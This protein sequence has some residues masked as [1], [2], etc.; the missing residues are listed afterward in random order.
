M[1]P[2]LLVL[3]ILGGIC[4]WGLL[5]WT[6]LRALFAKLSGWNRLAARYRAAGAEPSWQWRGQTVKVGLVRYR[7]TIRLAA[8]AEGLH[9]AETGLLRHPALCIPWCEM[10]RARPSS[11][12]GRPS[13]EVS[14]GMP[15]IGTIEFYAPLFHE[16]DLAAARHIHGSQ[17]GV[18]GVSGAPMSS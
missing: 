8:A 6:G 12:Y 18:R 15:A 4:V 16:I 7:R 3:A 5:L 11:F 14:V 13:V 17:G 1:S 2:E 9:L 10:T